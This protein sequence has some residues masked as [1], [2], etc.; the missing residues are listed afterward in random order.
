M[1]EAS[2]MGDGTGPPISRLRQIHV[3]ARRTIA[4]LLRSPRCQV[5]WPSRERLALG[6][7]VAVAAV[8]A[9][10]FLLDPWSLAAVRRLPVSVIEAFDRFTDLGLS[11]W[12]LWPLGIILI[13]LAVLDTSA[14][15]AFAR[16]VLAAWAVRLNFVFAAIA[17]PG[18]FVTIVKRLIGRARPPVA[19]GDVWAYLPFAWRADHASLP[20]GH[21]TTAFSALVAIGALFPQA[22][23]LLWIYAVLIAL[24]RVVVTAHYPSDVV[25]G[26]IVGTAGALL[27]RNWFAARRLGFLV[28]RDGAV[29]AMPGPSW[30]H[31]VKAI[32]RGLSSDR[33][34]PSFS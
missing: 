23:A 8:V 24:S 4:T 32:S 1:S 31:I 22:R 29:R 13:A 9:T 34:G 2:D 17:V 30:R 19:G 5:S 10:M 16:H 15:P 7:A 25:A 6:A 14:M 18:L 27:V 20:S 26:A 11:G 12:F 28:E 3:N 21:A 33:S